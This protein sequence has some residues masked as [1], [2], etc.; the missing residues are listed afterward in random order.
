MGL[1]ER[2]GG[3]S[4]SPP[5]SLPWPSSAR[6]QGSLSARILLQRRW[7][8][9]GRG[10]GPEPG[11]SPRPR[12]QING[13]HLAGEP[14]APP[15]SRLPPH[16]SREHLRLMS[17]PAPLHTSPRSSLISL[18]NDKSSW[19]AQAPAPGPFLQACIGLWRRVSTQI[20][21]QACTPRPRLTWPR[22]GAVCPVAGSVP[23][24]EPGKV[25]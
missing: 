11:P 8:A 5:A 20:H 18:G 24:L 12:P 10:G 2:A 25:S 15:P 16:R 7:G 23:G 9:E 6:T 13:N 21:T 22:L 4:P 19:A 17:A 1:H 3:L 14:H